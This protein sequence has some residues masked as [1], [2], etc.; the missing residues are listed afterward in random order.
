VFLQLFHTRPKQLG[1]WGI[2]YSSDDLQKRIDLANIDNC[3]PCKHSDIPIENKYKIQSGHFDI[4]KSS[5][6]SIKDIS[7]KDINA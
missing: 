2:V 7:I 4:K 6:N 3:G 5:N 1:R